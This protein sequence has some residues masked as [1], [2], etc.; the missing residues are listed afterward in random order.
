MTESEYKYLISESIDELR[1]LFKHNPHLFLTEEDVRCV[2]FQLLTSRLGLRRTYNGSLS[3]PV[4]SEV[5]WYG[6]D[7]NLRN[8][9]DVVILDTSDLRVTKD[10]FPLPSK[11]YGFNNFYGAIELKLRRV[12]GET[13]TKWIQ[14]LNKDLATLKSLKTSIVNGYDPL[15]VLIAF[16]RKKDISDKISQLPQEVNVVYECVTVTDSVH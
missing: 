2:L 4:H 14:L 3:S 8:R 7:Q 9:S 11:G 1:S 5:R 13:D 6:K 10:G 16:D 15:L 12:G